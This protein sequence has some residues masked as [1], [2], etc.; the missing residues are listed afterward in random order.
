M[1]LYRCKYCFKV[2]LGKAHM[3]CAICKDFDLC[4]ECFSVGAEVAPHKS[5]HPYVISESFSTSIPLIC[6]DWNIDEEIL[7]L[8]GIGKYGLEKWT[9]VAEYVE[10]KNKESC[11]EHY[12]NLYLNSPSF[13]LP[14]MSHV[15]GKSREQLLEMA[16]GQGEDKK[17]TT[18]VQICWPFEPDG[19]SHAEAAAIQKKS[20][21]GRKRKM[22]DR[23]RVSFGG[24][25]P[26]FSRTEGPGGYNE[27][28]QEFDIEYDNDAEELLTEMEFKDTDT[29]EERELKLRVLHIYGKRLDERNRRK[30]FVLE[31]NLLHPNPSE[32]DLTAEEKQ[33][34]G[35][36][37]SLMRFHSKE[38]HEE[39]LQTVI[40]EHR[41]RKR[42]EELKE[43]QAA[44]CRNSAEA[45]IYL[46]HKRRMEADASA[47]SAEGMDVTGYPGADLL[48]EPEKR[49]CSEQRLTPAVYLN[50]QGL[51]AQHILDGR[52]S[53]K[54]E[55]H[56]LFNM[57]TIKIDKVYDMLIRKGIAP[58]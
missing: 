44:G 53:T 38:E 30:N 51:L 50:M 31:R 34:C 11:M 3:K 14:D 49:L 13:P 28:R 25:K 23:V 32:N 35:K 41:T 39:L 18:D 36:Y 33:I 56:G 4:V 42:L 24:L 21:P 9:E 6:P 48:S 52:V 57:D 55:A 19:I 29:E 17:G 12:Q 10:T 2:I 27:K 5:D 45:D 8:E 43:A 20:T 37:D 40:A 1:A 26:R 58:P 22:K 15:A 46:M 16:K 54:V 47:S 7:L